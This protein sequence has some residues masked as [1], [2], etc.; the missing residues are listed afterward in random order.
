MNKYYKNGYC[1]SIINYNRIKTNQVIPDF[2]IYGNI[3]SIY[4]LKGDLVN[5]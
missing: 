1:D 3:T 2:L 5:A 4:K